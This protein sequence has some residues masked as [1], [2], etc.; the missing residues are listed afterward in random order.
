MV[1]SERTG[2]RPEAAKQ[3][4]PRPLENLPAADIAS[5]LGHWGPRTPGALRRLELRKQRGSSAIC[6]RS[7]RRGWRRGWTAMSRPPCRGD[8]P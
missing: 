6:D 1:M 4:Q 3:D 2:A 7:C 8:E 5:A